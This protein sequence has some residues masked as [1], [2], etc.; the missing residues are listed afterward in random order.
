MYFSTVDFF[1]F[2]FVVVDVAVARL[3]GSI[4]IISPKQKKKEIISKLNYTRKESKR[5]NK[6][7][8]EEKV[9]N[10]W[11]EMEKEK[12]VTQSESA[13][14]DIW[15]WNRILFSPSATFNSTKSN[16]ILSR[17]NA[18][19]EA[20]GRERNRALQMQEFLRERQRR[21]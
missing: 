20:R 5:G 18:C 1:F 3:I 7:E 4:G 21:W 6:K 13:R 2:S 11:I 19:V 15:L 8:H 14:T 16:I 12:N 9:K 17:P 10:K